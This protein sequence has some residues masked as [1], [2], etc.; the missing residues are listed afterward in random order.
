MI[1]SIPNLKHRS[2]NEMFPGADANAIDLIRRCLQFN[3]SRRPTAEEA[4]NHPYVAAFHV[5]GDAMPCPKV[6]RIQVDD[7]TK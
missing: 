4:L 3:P 6:I 7:N 5:D 1:E 2:L